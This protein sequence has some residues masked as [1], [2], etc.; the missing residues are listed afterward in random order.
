MAHSFS[1]EFRLAAACAI[2]PSSDRRQEAICTAAAEPLDWSRVLRVANRHQV[3]GLVHDGLKQVRLDVPPVIV[4]E[5]DTRAATL[6]R[7]NLEI[8]RESLRLQRLFDDA[9]LPVLFIKGAVLGLM[10]FGNLGLRDSQDIDLLVTHEILPAAT[11]VILRAGYRRVD[12]SSDISD[13][14]LRQVMPLR[15]DLGFIHQATSLRIEL[16]WRLFLNPHAMAETSIVASSRVVPLTGTAGLRTLGEED[17]FAY[18]CMHGALHWWNRLKWLADI[19]ALLA[20]LPEDSIERLVRAAEIRGLGRAV[21]QALLL[22]RRL[23]GTS[24]SAGLVATLCKSVTVRWLEATA[25]SAM[26]AGQ[27]ERDP[28]DAP[29]GTTRGSLS[30]FL[31]KRGWRYRLAELNVH[32]TNQGD[33]LALPLPQRLRFLYPVLRLPLWAWRHTVRAAMPKVAS[34]N[35]VGRGRNSRRGCLGGPGKL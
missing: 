19:N 20:T 30:T 32:L 14:Q 27:G 9:N 6:V 28:H 5:F 1:P 7:E 12:P 13:T 26:T 16:H 8:A 34:L 33:V 10:A 29:F 4:R 23:L 21:T 24:L 31:L 22:C 17:L 25:L 18:L 3:V 2:W 15:K 35:P 11:A